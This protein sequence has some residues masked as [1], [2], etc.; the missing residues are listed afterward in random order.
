[1]NQASLLFSFGQFRRFEKLQQLEWLESRGLLNSMCWGRGLGENVPSNYVHC[2]YF[3]DW[4]VKRAD[5][6]CEITYSG[7]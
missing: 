2:V 7:V 1:M 3:N 4:R 6:R 5:Q